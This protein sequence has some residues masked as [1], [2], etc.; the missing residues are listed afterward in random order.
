MK[1]LVTGAGGFIG[2]AA[3]QRLLDAGL[4]VRALVRRPYPGQDPR[5]QY[6]TVA[7]LAAVADWGPLLDGVDAVLHLAALAHQVGR[8]GEGRA[9]E[10][11]RVNVDLT[12]AI[13]RA[14]RT[15]GVRRFVFLS[16]VAAVGGRGRIAVDERTEPQPEGD[17]G[18]SKL[19]AEQAL[20][21]EL[22]G[23]GVSWIALRAP[24]VYGADNPG[25][26][27]RLLALLERGW[28]LPFGGLAN[29]RSFLYV[30]N[31]IDAI[32]NALRPE[33]RAEG[34][35]FLDDG[36]R[37]STPGLCRALAEARGLPVRLFRFPWSLMRLLGAVGSAAERLLGREFPIS[38]YSVEKLGGSLVVDGRRF[39]E[40]AR[41]R[42]PVD[43]QEAIR[44]TV[45]PIHRA[46][47]QPQG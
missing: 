38:T 47:P 24:L 37:Y 5:A 19:L 44:C 4:E 25:N 36:T 41:W 33:C 39:A 34:V 30:E 6:V 20:A 45:T 3:V 7:D 42:P 9:A 15:T 18:R 26:M 8:R 43:R 10:F 17:Y 11:M 13:A 28:P 35:F 2:R 14:A 21:R 29:E 16:S 27:A 22:G 1:V 46:G 12:A 32:L 40:I 23:S 31:L